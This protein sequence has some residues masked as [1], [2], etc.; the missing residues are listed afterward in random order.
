MLLTTLHAL[1]IPFATAVNK[2]L[3]MPTTG[4]RPLFATKIPVNLDGQTKGHTVSV[5]SPAASVFP[6]DTAASV[7]DRFL[8][9]HH[10]IFPASPLLRNLRCHI[11][12]GLPSQV[13]H[14][15]I[16]PLPVEKLVPPQK[17]Q[18]QPK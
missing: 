14:R 8:P 16:S 15:S 9:F 13:N 12:R 11:R 17:T 6:S 1:Q 18:A 3:W 5:P 2:P 7:F 4:L 10:P